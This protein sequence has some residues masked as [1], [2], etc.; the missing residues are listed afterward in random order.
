MRGSI[1]TWALIAA[2][3]WVA[4]GVVLGSGAF[5]QARPPIPPGG[6]SPECLPASYNHSASLPGTSVDVSPEPGTVS[7]SPDTQVSFLGAPASQIRNVVVTASRTHGHSGT[8]RPFS[9]G[10]GASFV[11]RKPFEAH[12]TVTVH[13]TIG[14]GS[15]RPAEF[16]FRTAT[17]YPTAGLPIFPH[18]KTGPGDVQTFRSRP[19]LQPPSVQISGSPSSTAAG[20]L[21]VTPSGGPGQWGQMIF[22]NRGQLVWFNPLPEGTG[23]TD[24]RVQRYRGQSVLTYW[25]GSITQDGF[26]VGHDVILDHNYRTVARINAGNGYAADLHEFTISPRSTALISFFDPIRCDLKPKGGSRG[27]VMLDS[28]FEEIDVQTGLVRSEWHAL[29]HIAVDDSYQ[30]PP[31][32]AQELWD[33]FH[34]NSIDETG[35]GDLLISARNTSAIYLLKAG[36]G[37]V[38]WILDGK[39]STFKMGPGTGIA[40]QHDARF[41]PDGTISVFDDEAAPR[42]GF[43]SRGIDIAL[44]YRTHR[45]TLAR[46]YTHA[47]P[48]ASDSQGNMQSL[49][50]GDVLVGWGQ[51]P[52][53]TEYTADGRQLF[54]AQMPLNDG[55]YRAYR[56][57]WSGQPLTRPAL[58]AS[59][60]AGDTTAAYASWNGATDVATWRLLAGKDRAHLAQAATAPGGSFETLLYAYDAYPY[61]QVQALDGSGRVLS[62]SAVT[63]VAGA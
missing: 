55:S 51:A 3:A 45:A 40:Y 13:A 61:V 22:D 47:S 23:T 12:E 31:T 7:A 56:M 39:S 62:S 42:S 58:S 35:A 8:L 16:S 49:P 59:I 24:L 46:S 38:D 37:A 14:A 50:N 53:I 32:G 29:D 18:P 20:D 6:P 25:Q 30:T 17:P 28:G 33:Y 41:R 34:I 57:R 4:I 63:K 9:Q 2:A 11:P 60:M 43:E 19:D 15:G 48:I 26:G 52:E 54:E 27:G 21:F 1:K 5:T 10:D 36:S 44:D